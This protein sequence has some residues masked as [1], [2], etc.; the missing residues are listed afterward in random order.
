MMNKLKKDTKL[1]ANEE[2]TARAKETITRKM[3]TCRSLNHGKIN[4]TVLHTP[5]FFSLVVVVVVSLQKQSKSLHYVERTHFF[6]LN[7]NVFPRI[8]QNR[9]HFAWISD[10]KK[11]T[12]STTPD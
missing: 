4:K 2:T 7:K 10:L 11:K 8:A 9:A 5:S 12:T 3:E 6:D 1:F